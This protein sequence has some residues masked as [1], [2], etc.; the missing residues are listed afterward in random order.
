MAPML[1]RVGIRFDENGWMLAVLALGVA[2]MLAIALL[3]SVAVG[4]GDRDCPEF[5]DQ[6]AAQIFYLKH[7]GPRYD[8][9]RLDAD[10][11]G[12]ACEDD[13]CPCYYK[14]HL[15]K[16][17]ALASLAADERSIAVG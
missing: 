10:H 6:R 3:P 9:D 7:G 5:P 1:K 11:D 13:P 8:P 12:I 14:T 16:R 2:V 15:P 17:A 4:R